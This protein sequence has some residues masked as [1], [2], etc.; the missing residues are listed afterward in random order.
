MTS[1]KTKQNFDF[2]NRHAQSTQNSLVASSLSPVIKNFLSETRWLVTAL[3][4][5]PRRAQ[6]ILRV[7]SITKDNARILGFAPVYKLYRATEDLYKS[8]CDEKTGVTENIA[9]LVSAVARKIEECCAL[10]EKDDLDSLSELDI[11]PYLIYLDK[12][13]TGEIFDARALFG[14]QHALEDKSATRANAQSQ[15][16]KDALIQIQSSK[17]AQLVNQHEEMIARS[18]I[19][20]N[21]VELLKSAIHTG[22]LKIA[23]EAYK[24]LASDTQN[25]QS[26]L[27]Q[28]H[29]QLMSFVQDDAFLAR[30]QDFQGFF[31]LANGRKYLIPAEFVLD[32]ISESPLNYEEKQ[33]QKILVSIQENESGSDEKR[34]EI[35][36]YALSSLLPGTPPAQNPVMDTIILVNY[37]SQKIGI[38]V[39]SMLKFVSLIKKPM[40]KAFDHFPILLGLAFDEKY[41]MIPILSVPEI[42]KKFKA[43]RGYDV[44]KFVVSTR[45]HIPRILV[46]DD[47]DTTRL[48]EHTIVETNGFLVDEAFDGIDAIAKLKERAFDLIITDD[49]MPRMDG[50][51]LLDNVRRMEHYKS[52]PVIAL[53]TTPIPKSDVFISK[54]DFRR[55]ELVQKIKELLHE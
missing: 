28:T 13:V 22:D 17:I 50:E 35:P 41:D 42:M 10:I 14:S 2:L 6:E 27:M 45:K 31:V 48:I 12:A 52:V 33:N 15:E 30:H 36:I 53:A 21:Q 11:L 51:I 34:E 20:T 43:M 55:N 25:L 29:D 19:L 8:I 23:K 44:K 26:N 47:S 40:P 1:E 49:A 32:V 9:V 4:K 39:D 54:S 16:E 3:K 7:I 18:Y 5:Q 38:I 46:V 24:L 37:Q